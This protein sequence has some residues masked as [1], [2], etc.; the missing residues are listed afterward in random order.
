MTEE[1]IIKLAAKTGAKE[2]MEAYKREQ[3]SALKN[4]NDKRLCNTE[5][6]LRH[7]RAFREASENA[8][9]R[10]EECESLEQIIADLMLNGQTEN[11]TVQS[12]KQS[13]ARTAVIVQHIEKMLALYQNYCFANGKPEDERRWR[14]IDGLYI[15]NRKKSIAELATQESVC[16]RQIYDD[17]TNA[18]SKIA[19]YMF[20]IDF[21]VF[22]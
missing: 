21:V 13:A 22:K 10:A 17:R 14:V 6:L 3:Q 8:V 11:V 5:L 19:V 9:F 2:G 16:E 4:A 20:G 18:I 1:E 15:Q 12:I 7:Y